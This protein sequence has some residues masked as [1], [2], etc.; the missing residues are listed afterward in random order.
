MTTCFAVFVLLGK[1]RSD[2]QCGCVNRRAGI[3]EGQA[4]AFQ[5]GITVG[6]SGG[7]NH[8]MSLQCVCVGVSPS[9][10]HRHSYADFFFT[11]PP[12]LQSDFFL[13]L[14]VW[15]SLWFS[16]KLWENKHIQIWM[17]LC[18]QSLWL[19][20]LA[21]SVPFEAVFETFTCLL[22]FLFSPQKLSNPFIAS[23]PL[24]Q[25]SRST[26]W[27]AHLTTLIK[28]KHFSTSLH[29]PSPKLVFKISSTVADQNS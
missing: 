10:C 24:H 13:F 29:L 15:N 28:K 23:F 27:R 18:R 1:A 6:G 4:A 16:C 9:S 20:V 3:A 2:S 11:P 22:I 19:M 17:D 14:E 5:T 7:W 12:P 21:L 8:V 26:S 25:G